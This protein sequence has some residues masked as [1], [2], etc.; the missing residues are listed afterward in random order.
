[1]IAKSTF[2]SGKIDSGKAPITFNDDVALTVFDTFA[3]PGA[4]IGEAGLLY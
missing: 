1:M 3:A 2:P 4:V